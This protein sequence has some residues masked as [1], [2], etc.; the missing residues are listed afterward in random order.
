MMS[1]GITSLDQRRAL[2]KMVERY[3]GADLL[4]STQAGN[5]PATARDLDGLRL[6]TLIITGSL[7][8]S[9]RKQHAQRILA[10]LPEAREV[11]IEGAG[12]LS[13]L[14]HPRDYNERLIEFCKA[15]E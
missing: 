11:V 5:I 14:T 15:A 10:L 3:K 12:H 4:H 2:R 9:V 13:N 7:E 1:R 8:V 6:P